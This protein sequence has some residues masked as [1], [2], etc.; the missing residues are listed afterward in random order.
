MEQPVQS[1]FWHYINYFKCQIN[2]FALQSFL[3]IVIGLPLIFLLLTDLP[4]LPCCEVNFYLLC[5]LISSLVFWKPGFMSFFKRNGHSEPPRQNMSV[6]SFLLWKSVQF[7]SKNHVFFSSQSGAFVQSHC[8]ISQPVDWQ[9]N[10]NLPSVF[11]ECCFLAMCILTKWWASD[12][13][14]YSGCEVY[15]GCIYTHN[16]YK[17][18]NCRRESSE[19]WEVGDKVTQWPDSVKSSVSTIAA[20]WIKPHDIWQDFC[21]AEIPCLSKLGDHEIVDKPCSLHRWKSQV[22]SLLLLCLWI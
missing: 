12:C 6:H 5:F 11:S 15:L 19:L 22:G 14:V 17:S 10:W 2:Y 21:L 18:G 13:T 20:A 9:K 7:F 4:F 8:S 1:F 3:D 16:N